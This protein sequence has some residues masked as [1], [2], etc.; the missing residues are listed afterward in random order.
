MRIMKQLLIL[1]VAILAAGSLHAQL[2]NTRWKV[3]LN[4]GD[5]VE[6]VFDFSADSLKVYG[7]TDSTQFETM[8]YTVKDSVLSLLK[9]YGQSAC[10]TTSVGKYKFAIKENQLTASLLSD[11]CDPRS[12]VL[13]KT[14]WTKIP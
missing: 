6:T 1:S 13:D 7:A 14:I 12:S 3:T 2:A 10:S 8:S 11:D 9:A 5:Q 4:L